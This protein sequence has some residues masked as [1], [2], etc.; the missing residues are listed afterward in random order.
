M[1]SEEVIA[2]GNAEDRCPFWFDFVRNSVPFRS[3]RSIRPSK[4][5]YRPLVYT[6]EKENK[7]KTEK[8]I[9]RPP[10][11]KQVQFQNISLSDDLV[12]SPHGKGEKT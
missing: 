12:S 7:R 2:E 6:E 5:E 8:D 3:V 9:D 10:E 11:T 1:K 4:R